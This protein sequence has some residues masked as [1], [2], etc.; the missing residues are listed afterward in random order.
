MKEKNQ[1]PE[2]SGEQ[3]VMEG[4][5][6]T[7]PPEIIDFSKIEEKGS[8]E[9]HSS[10][11][12]EM[13]DLFADDGEASRVKAKQTS[14]PLKTGLFSR[15]GFGS[16]AD[17]EKEEAVREDKKPSGFLSVFS[18]E[19]KMA[20]PPRFDLSKKE[21]ADDPLNA[22]FVPPEAEAPRALYKDDFFSSFDTEE[23]DKAFA[24][25]RRQRKETEV[26]GADEFDFWTKK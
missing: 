17:S 4:A 2:A 12:D 6:Y 20:P 25:I 14:A 7:E 19:E 23:D 21:E 9:S 11:T 1:T 26:H 22:T 5:P 24:D 16:V 18:R 13:L 3:M 8:S 10:V 15:L